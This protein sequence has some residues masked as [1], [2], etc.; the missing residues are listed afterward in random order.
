MAKPQRNAAPDRIARPSRT[1]FVTTK[2]HS[3]TAL[4]QSEQ[5]AELLVDVLRS[6]VAARRF[7]LHDFVIMP[8]HVHLLLTV[9]GETTVEKAMQFVKGGFSFRIRRETGFTREV[10]QRGYELQV[11]DFRS[12][13]AS[14][15]SLT[16]ATSC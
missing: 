9:S 11:K 5:N 10:W 15:S 6:C 1:F 13:I 8:N 3:A 14:A 7:Q 4:F 2:T 12:R 16:S